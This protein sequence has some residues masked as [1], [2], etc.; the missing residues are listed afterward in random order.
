MNN[1]TMLGAS[2]RFNTREKATTLPIDA[3][4]L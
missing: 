2:M 4:P 1:V 3:V